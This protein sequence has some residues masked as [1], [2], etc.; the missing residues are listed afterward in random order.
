MSTSYFGSANT[1]SSSVG[2]TN[3]PQQSKRTKETGQTRFEYDMQS[4][5]SQANQGRNLIADMKGAAAMD[6]QTAQHDLQQWAKLWPGLESLY[7]EAV[8]KPAIKRI[9]EK[10]V[11]GSNLYLTHGSSINEVIEQ[12]RSLGTLQDAGM[13]SQKMA[14]AIYTKLQAEGNVNARSIADQWSAMGDAGKN[15]FWLQAMRSESKNYGLGAIQR[16]EEYE[17][18]NGV[19]DA[20]KRLQWYR[21]DLIEWS[22][23]EKG[24]NPQGFRQSIVNEY[25]LKEPNKWIQQQNAKE[26]ENETVGKSKEYIDNHYLDVQN[27]LQSVD[28]KAGKD[29]YLQSY[30]ALTYHYKKLEQHGKLGGKSWKEALL[31]DF[32]QQGKDIIKA[33]PKAERMQVAK[34]LEEAIQQTHI[35]QTEIDPKD[36]SIISTK[37]V[38]VMPSTGLSLSKAQPV[39]F[40]TGAF[41]NYAKGLDNA[42]YDQDIKN[43]RIQIGVINEEVNSSEWKHPEHNVSW[44]ELTKRQRRDYLE[45]VTKDLPYRHDKQIKEKIEDLVEGHNETLTF[46]Q[47]E[48]VVARERGLHGRHIPS[49]LLKN[50]ATKDLAELQQKYDF[51]PVDGKGLLQ[52]SE[53]EKGTLANLNSSLKNVIGNKQ[54]L[55]SNYK[56]WAP[57]RKNAYLYAEQKRDLRAQDIID[58]APEGEKPT[59]TQAMQQ[60]TQE[61]TTQILSERNTP[62]AEFQFSPDGYLQIKAQIESNAWPMGGQY[63]NESHR[64]MWNS[65]KPIV[66]ITSHHVNAFGETKAREILAKSFDPNTL[67]QAANLQTGGYSGEQKMVSK[68]LGYP[69]VADMINDMNKRQD[70]NYEKPPEQDV[71]SNSLGLGNIYAINNQNNLGGASFS[72]TNRIFSSKG[73]AQDFNFTSQFFGVD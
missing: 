31:D 52:N 19:M 3:I 44:S 60:A 4:I 35:T 71:V 51:K 22:S 6:A 53:S 49:H 42:E 67:G 15:G 12:Q 45:E 9:K 54:Y 65:Y 68:L 66:G 13:Y 64:G 69:T 32:S 10:H 24:R 26:W 38:R 23:P 2:G 16:R 72:Q 73:G 57:E 70:P 55:G 8:V 47:A 18:E 37:D 46:A 5:D 27:K 62:G 17:K 39:R 20:N 34:A 50:V 30:P 25:M 61:I 36:G 21:Q 56:D 63:S 33:T 29:L 40:Q 1:L 43:S 59:Q 41:V 11:E 58:A 28:K 14:D 48:T 7:K